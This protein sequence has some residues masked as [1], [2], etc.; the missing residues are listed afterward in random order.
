[1]RLCPGVATGTTET[2]ARFVESS[3]NGGMFR[4]I[5]EGAGL[6]HTNRRAAAAAAASGPNANSMRAVGACLTS[7]ISFPATYQPHLNL[8]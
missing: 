8:V 3:G 6:G 7:K 5:Q 2:K 1:M 4:R